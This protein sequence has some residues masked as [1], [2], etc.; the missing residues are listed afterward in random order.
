MAKPSVH[1]QTSIVT[2]FMTFFIQRLLADGIR[3]R[4][5]SRA[6][7][8]GDQEEL[9]STSIEASARRAAPLWLPSVR[10]SP[11]WFLFA[12]IPL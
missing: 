7:R 10:A 12:V 3:P 1:T 2:A 6:Y 5:S 8:K 9:P 4:T 11:L